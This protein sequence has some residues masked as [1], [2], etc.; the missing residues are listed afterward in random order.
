MMIKEKSGRQCG[1][2]LDYCTLKLLRLERV[3]RE[4]AHDWSVASELTRGWPGLAL[5]KHGFLVARR[6]ELRLQAD[7]LR[8]G[9]EFYELRFMETG[10]GLL[11]IRIRH[12]FGCGRLLA[13]DVLCE[14][15]VVRCLVERMQLLGVVGRARR[16][17]GRRA[18]W[19]GSAGPR[20]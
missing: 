1:I 6:L 4:L 14:N 5:Y 19:R 18:I 20:K 9:K 12:D 8:D 11:G 7:Y 13:D 3:F 15:R 2:E 17:G 16:S 10:P